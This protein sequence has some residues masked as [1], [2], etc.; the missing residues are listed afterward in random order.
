MK[1]IITEVFEF[2]ELSKEAKERARQW[3]RECDSDYHWSKE[4]LNS[5]K[6]LAEHF[7]GKLKDW[8]VDWGNSSY[9]SAEFD[10]PELEENEIKDLLK[11]LGTYDK[12]TLKG[13]GDCKLTGYSADEDAIDGFRQAYFKGERDLDELMKESFKTWLKACQADYEYQNSNEAVDESINAND[14]TFTSEGERFGN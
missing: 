12:K 7:S 10:M 8:S 6:A 2:N 13:H 14:Y 9:S 3:Y 1:Q 5:L 11:K 4:A